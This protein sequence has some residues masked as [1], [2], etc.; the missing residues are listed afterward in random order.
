MQNHLRIFFLCSMGLAC[1]P[2]K[3]S[4][5]QIATSFTGYDRFG[6]AQTC[7]VINESTCSQVP[8]TAIHY[9]NACNAT[10]G[11][12]GLCAC[13][14]FLCSVPVPN[15]AASVGQMSSAAV[16]PDAV[17]AT[18]TATMTTTSTTMFPTF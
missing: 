7:Y 10:R 2:R 14:N 9:R 3:D 11:T 16:M 15:A 17:T 4:A 5:P 1:S 12:Y 6:R 13:N 18:A 8:S